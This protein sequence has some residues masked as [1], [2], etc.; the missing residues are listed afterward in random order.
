M[1]EIRRGEVTWDPRLAALVDVVRGAAERMGEV[2]NATW[3]AARSAG[4][5]DREL[6]DAFA[7]I[8]AN[9]F[10]NYFNHYVGTELDLPAAPALDPSS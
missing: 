8:V 7:S 10:T 3:E 5:S 1:V 9:L 2:G 4:W 6:A